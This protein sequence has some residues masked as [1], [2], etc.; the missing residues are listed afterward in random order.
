MASNTDQRKRAFGRSLKKRREE[1]GLTQE[2]LARYLGVDT[3][4]ISEWERSYRTPKKLTQIGVFKMLDDLVQRMA[5]LTKK[6][7][8]E[9]NAGHVSK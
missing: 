3:P 1:L 2:Q 9:R 8:A 6:R 7:Q 4:R 5:D